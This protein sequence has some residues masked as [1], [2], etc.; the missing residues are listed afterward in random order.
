MSPEMI[1][2]ILRDCLN[3]VD[4]TT[5]IEQEP[6][7]DVYVIYFD[8]ETSLRIPGQVHERMLRS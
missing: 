4:D 5:H 7:Y 2:S 3:S 8:N 1:R 6:H